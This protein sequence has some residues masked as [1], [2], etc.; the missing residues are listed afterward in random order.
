VESAKW[1]HGLWDHGLWD[2]SDIGINFSEISKACL[3]LVQQKCVSVNGVIRLLE[4]V[5]LGPKT[6]PLSGAHYIFV[7]F[8]KL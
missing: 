5:W 3:A 8:N 7:G 1:D 2:H 4:S 6:I